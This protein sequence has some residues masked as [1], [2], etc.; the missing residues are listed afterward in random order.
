MAYKF[1]QDFLIPRG[2]LKSR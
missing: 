2:E 1:I